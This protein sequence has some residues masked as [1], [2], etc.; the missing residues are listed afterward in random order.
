[1]II[2][3]TFIAYDDN[4]LM[5]VT[6]SS[7]YF[8]YLTVT[9][10][11]KTSSIGE[12]TITDDQII[13]NQILE[14]NTQGF[15]ILVDRYKDLVFTLALRMLKQREEAE[16]VSQDVFIKVFRSLTKFK[17]DSKL[18]TWIYKI[19]Y[20]SCLDALKK[21]KRKYQEI[22]IDKFEGYEIESIDNAFEM[23][24]KEERE[25]TIKWCIQQLSGEDS[26]ILTLFYFEELSLDEISKI[27]G[28]KPNNVKVKLHRARKRLA[29]IMKEK[30]EPEI[31]T[32][33]GK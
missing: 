19:A 16:E 5:M 18:S 9:L 33:Y 23:L 22:S 2:F 26:S 24:V 7:K 32:H 28:L 31:I 17:G 11:T 20:N 14:G 21:T 27:I 3:N 25:E 1:L 30:L 12:M 8:F 10:V 13:I 29:I 4:F 6:L 15:S